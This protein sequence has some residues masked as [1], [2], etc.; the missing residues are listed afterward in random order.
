M[1]SRLERWIPELPDDA[2]TAQRCRWLV[3][4]FY[5]SAVADVY[6]W[7]R[8]AEGLSGQWEPKLGLWI[9]HLIPASYAHSM[10]YP[11]V[12]VMAGSAL[13]A[14]VAPQIRAARIGYCLSLLL[15]MAIFMDGKNKIDHAHHGLWWSSFLLV[16]L[17]PLGPKMTADHRRALVRMLWTVMAVLLLFYSLAGLSKLLASLRHLPFDR[18]TWLSWDALAVTVVRDQRSENTLLGSFL[19]AHPVLSF[20]L[21]LGVLYLELFAIV[22]A[23]RLRLA[24]LFGASLVA[25]HLG[26]RFT[27]GISFRPATFLLILFVI[28]NPL[29]VSA[30]VRATL[31]ELPLFGRLIRRLWPATGDPE[32]G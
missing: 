16:F 25:L 24:R 10:V 4:I 7:A 21:Q 14:A 1:W 27:M 26:I 11:L 13:L 31:G 6:L 18:L 23:F 28:A 8:V 32:P 29:A 5:G 3:T 17:P 15:V 30:G 20:T 19:L 9:S 12:L 22:A 2:A